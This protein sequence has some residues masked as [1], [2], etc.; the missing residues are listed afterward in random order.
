MRDGAGSI[1]LRGRMWNRLRPSDNDL[2]STMQ[3]WV[4]RNTDAPQVGAVKRRFAPRSDGYAR[5]DEA[6]MWSRPTSWGKRS[7]AR[8]S[9]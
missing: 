1:G 3:C 8:M 5:P 2:Q 7:L 9:H 6:I 4:K